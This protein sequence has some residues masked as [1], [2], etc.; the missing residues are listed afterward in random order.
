MDGRVSVGY[1]V[2]GFVSFRYLF[3]SCGY[4]EFF[5]RELMVLRERRYI[6][7]LNVDYDILSG[8][9]S[10]SL[11]YLGFVYDKDF[12]WFSFVVESLWL[13]SFFSG[14]RRIK[15]WFFYYGFFIFCI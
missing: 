10:N 5:Y 14:I 9:E 7:D 2:S 13:D 6:Y 4:D 11:L 15:F 8:R 12:E 3:Y 1:Y